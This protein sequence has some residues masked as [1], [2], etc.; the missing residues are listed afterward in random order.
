MPCCPPH[1]N[2]PS[3]LLDT[4]HAPALNDL[5]QFFP[6]GLKGDT[7]GLSRLSMLPSL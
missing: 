2:S 1:P 7:P 4:H 6:V 3:A 5:P